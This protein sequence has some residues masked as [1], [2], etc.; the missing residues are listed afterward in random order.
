LVCLLV[1]GSM[2]AVPVAAV[3]ILRFLGRG[4]SLEET[5]FRRR[6]ACPHCGEMI[7]PEATVCRS[8]GNDLP[9]N[10]TVARRHI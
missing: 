2:A 10:W 5:Q 4:P 7:L 9:H 8:C 3:L 6:I 1:A